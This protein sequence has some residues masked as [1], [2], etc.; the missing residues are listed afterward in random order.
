MGNRVGRFVVHTK[1]PGYVGV[2][3]VV[4]W[5]DPFRL[6]LELDGSGDQPI[7]ACPE[8]ALADVSCGGDRGR[9]RFLWGGGP[10]GHDEYGLD[11]FWRKE[12]GTP[13]VGTDLGV[14]DHQ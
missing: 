1:K 4:W 6:G 11:G 9:L 13:L 8:I 10:V 12:T 3:L 2:G 7:S 14:D 5:R